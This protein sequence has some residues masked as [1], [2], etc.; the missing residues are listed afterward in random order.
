MMD[1]VL[2]NCNVKLIS[3]GIDLANNDNDKLTSQLETIVPLI[4]WNYD[5]L[6]DQLQIS[7]PNGT[8]IPDSLSNYGDVM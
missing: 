4:S 5:F 6:N 8:I 3:Q 7:V 2:T 1:I